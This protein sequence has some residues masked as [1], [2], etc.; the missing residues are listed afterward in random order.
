MSADLPVLL[1]IAAGLPH[2]D[3]GR[4]HLVG[5]RHKASRNRAV[6]RG[7]HA[8]FPKLAQHVL[9]K[10]MFLPVRVGFAL[11]SAAPWYLERGRKRRLKL[12]IRSPIK[13]AAVPLTGA[14]R[15]VS[16]GVLDGPSSVAPCCS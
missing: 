13:A 9:R 15:T 6:H 8:H 7:S 5:R 16:P 2:A 14:V 11:E 3:T 10:S 4:T 1:H 12:Q